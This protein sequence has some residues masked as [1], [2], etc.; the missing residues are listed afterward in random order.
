[1]QW[2][3]STCG[4]LWAGQINMWGGHSCP[5]PLTFL[6]VIAFRLRAPLLLTIVIPNRLQPVRNL[7]FH[8][9]PKS[10]FLA[11]LGV[12]RGG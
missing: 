2:K 10:R 12:T 1:M 6:S 7:L 11:S 9:P 3:M 8:P 5:P 4:W